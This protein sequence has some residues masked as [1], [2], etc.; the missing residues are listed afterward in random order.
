MNLCSLA[1]SSSGNCIYVGSLNT[2]LL[3][4]IGI[5]GKK[6]ELGLKEIG[7]DIKALNGILITHEH[8]DHIKGLGVIS[9]RYKIPIFA[10]DKTIE[11]VK[12]QKQIGVIDESLFNIINPDQEFTLNDICIKPFSISHDAVDPVCYTM[13]CSDKK[14][15]VA[16]DL[17]CY[18][19]YIVDH[20]KA[21]NVLFIEANHDVKMLEVG[22]YPYFL[23]Q[24][25]LSDVGHL[26]NEMSG[27]L[28]NE[29]F[30]DELKYIVLGHLSNENNH[31]DVAYES[32]KVELLSQKLHERNV[33]LI[34]ASKFM[35]SKLISI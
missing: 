9:R 19:T 22:S 27:K 13:S 23:K 14:I 20:L 30:H 1:S 31:D 6:A 21:S 4:D 34:V 8:S 29:L 16:T 10:T 12:N 7:V 24:R 32:V 17:G 26:S 33:E 5:S 28:L 35:N 25:I 11:K 15:S 18:N 2:S 3:I